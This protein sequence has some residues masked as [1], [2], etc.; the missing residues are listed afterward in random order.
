MSDM[1]ASSWVPQPLGK[2]ALWA[3]GAILLIATIYEVNRKVGIALAILAVMGML[4]IG[5]QRFGWSL[6]TE[7]KV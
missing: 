5:A 6:A 7:T 4:L 3:I 2:G 1:S